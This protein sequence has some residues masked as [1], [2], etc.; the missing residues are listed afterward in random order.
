VVTGAGDGVDVDVDVDGEPVDE[1]EPVEDGVELVS[2]VVVVVVAF[3]VEVF[4]FAVRPGSLPS[5]SWMKITPHAAMKAATD[6]PIVR[7]RIRW[8]R[9]RRAARGSG[10]GGGGAVGE[11]VVFMATSSTPALNATCVDPGSCLSRFS[12]LILRFGPAGAEGAAR[13]FTHP[14]W[15]FNLKRSHWIRA[16]VVAGVCAVAGA[17]AGIVGSAAAPT[18]K[19]SS[20]RH[21]W[22][23]RPG[24]PRGDFHGPPV[25]ADA[26][27]L[28]KAGNG[29]ITVTEDS[30]KLKSVA[31][32]DLTITEGVGSVTY[33][34]V[35]VTVP[36]G[37][38]V[39]RN[40]SKA[41]LG[42]LKAGDQVHVES[43]S[44]GANVGAFD[45]QHG[46]ARFGHR[47]GPRG[48]DGGPPPGAPGPPPGY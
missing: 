5:A 45:A 37:A 29:F 47:F 33:K 15:R 43:S 7:L 22:P 10:R 32:N 36:S 16:G 19:K 34:D 17:T 38:T 24:G 30:G 11:G 31:G 35:T 14:N 28:N 40:G 26:V 6:Q 46:P 9:S 18:T 42:D 1:P 13:C 3:V 21:G 12:Q 23:G 25:H 41:A 8:M 2:V 20:T 48:P 27:V 44:E 39:Y 4:D